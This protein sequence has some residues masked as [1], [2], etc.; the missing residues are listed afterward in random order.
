MP[1]MGT[2]LFKRKVYDEFI[3][4]SGCWRAQP[5]IFCNEPDGPKITNRKE[6]SAK[7]IALMKCGLFLIASK[8]W[9]HSCRKRNV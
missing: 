1:K 2:W 4:K 7:T 5:A 3:N 6:I 8:H 9:F